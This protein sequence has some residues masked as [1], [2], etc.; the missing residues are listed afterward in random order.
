MNASDF[1][2]I[3]F[4]LHFTQC[5]VMVSLDMFFFLF[6]VCLVVVEEQINQPAFSRLLTCQCT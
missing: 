1:V 5:V 4:S 2:R 6:S 3:D